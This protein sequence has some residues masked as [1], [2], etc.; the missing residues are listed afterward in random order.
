MRKSKWA[1][2]VILLLPFAL[3][4]SEIYKWVDENGVVHYTDKPPENQSTSE[5]EIKEP[6]SEAEMK[7]A[8]AIYRDAIEQAQSRQT[9]TQES[10]SPVLSG[11]KKRATQMTPDRIKCFEAY[12]A[13]RDLEKRGDVYEDEAGKIHHWQS[14]HSFW[15]ESYRKRLTDREKREY[16]DKFEKQMKQVCDLP[17]REIRKGADAWEKTYYAGQC[18]MAKAK[19]SRLVDDK[20][21]VGTFD[22]AEELI[23]EYCK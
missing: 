14:F 22:Y 16:V 6:P 4:G 12:L 18:S 10:S 20:T 17:R 9:S 23:S 5:V 1:V 21:P 3:E 8:D 19:L 11:Q 13:I 2:V 15:Y 7:E